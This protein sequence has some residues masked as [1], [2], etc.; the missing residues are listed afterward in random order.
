MQERMFYA[1]FVG[2]NAYPQGAALSGCV[3]DVLE[4][5]LL[6]REQCAQ[7]TGIRYNPVYY[8]APNDADALRME[9]HE[10]ATGEKLPFQPPTFTNIS[11]SLFSHFN[12]AKEGD[13]CVFYYSGHGSQTEAPPE[14]GKPMMETIVCVDSRDE[15]S[16]TAR[17]L[18]DKELAWLLWKTFSAKA[19]HVLVLMDCCHSGN[20]T[21]SLKNETD[22]RFRFIPSERNKIPYEQYLG[23]GDAGFYNNTGGKISIKI[24]RYVHL[25]ACRDDE[26]AQE[27]MQGG[28]FTNRL[29]EALRAGGTARS[30]RQLMQGLTISV[31][32]RAERQTPVAFALNE[33]DLDQQFLSPDIQPYKPYFNLRYN[34]REKRWKL[35]GGAMHRLKK[36]DVVKVSDGTKEVE[37]VLTDVQETYSWLDVQ[38]FDE[39]S[40]QITAVLLRAAEPMMKVGVPAALKNITGQFPFFSLHEETAP[41]VQYVVKQLDTGA[42]VLLPVNGTM[43][44]F[45]R[46]TNAAVFL[47]HINKVG[48]WLQTLELQH[49]AP[50][51][52][53]QDFVFEWVAEPGL[54]L[55]EGV[56]LHYDGDLYPSF[57]LRIS[58]HPQSPL[59]TCYVKAL[60]LGSKY[61]IIGSLIRND[62]NK[63]ENKAGSYIDLSM[64]YGGE[65]YTRIPVSI[66]EK[67]SRYNIHSVTDYLKII[68]S[69]KPVQLDQYEQEGLELD[70]GTVHRDLAAPPKTRGGEAAKDQPQ[71]SVFTFRVVCKRP[72][73]E[74]TLKAGEA[75]EFDTFSITAPA[76]FNARIAPAVAEN[77]T[78][79]ITPD[80]WGPVLTEE[81]LDGKGLLLYPEQPLPE[82]SAITLQLKPPAAA[83]RSLKDEQ[84]EEMILPYSFDPVTQQ[85]IPLGYA[86]DNGQV[87]IE[88]LPASAERSIG[89]AVKLYFKKIF[90]PKQ[91][92]QL[93]VPPG[94]TGKA[95][96]LIHGFTGETRSMQEAYAADGAVLTYDYE[97]MATPVAKTAELLQAALLQAG[98][99][100]TL[101]LTIVA[102]GT[103]GLV[104][105]WLVEQ[106]GAPYVKRLVLVGVPNAGSSLAA[107]TASATNLLTDALNFTG[108]V[109]YAITGLAWVLKFLKLHPATA[110]QEMQPGSEL[111]QKLQSSAMAKGVEY[112]VI[113][114]DASLIKGN[115]IDKAIV[116]AFG[117]ERNDRAVTVTSMQAIAG[118]EPQ[119]VDVVPCH[120]LGYFRKEAGIRLT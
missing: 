71:W 70:D 36:G 74:Q 68:V 1:A 116:H 46:E 52:R 102:H 110:F 109:K 79:S 27:T 101:E 14:F 15:N 77:T 104:A 80:L 98:A 108:P 4:L 113:A 5:D 20:N 10:T 19:A 50:G 48:S 25:A 117:K 55:A 22:V 86:D 99:D 95:T 84:L 66:D 78:R 9:A 100:K 62:S 88:R 37:A 59:K 23:Y 89:G 107:L 65:E 38:G 69:D 61:S 12:D 57:G 21:R 119:Q 41:G 45:K 92:N 112:K 90:R 72:P 91:V 81:V 120:H 28:L 63:L 6:F 83:V 35:Y 96:L 51:I 73:A 43:P 17:D 24:P 42:Y 115:L 103:G 93:V 18:I 47:A 87:F 11:A 118:L 58:I 44:L 64:A 94:L 40:Q 85:F 31:G 111:M 32:N 54:T 29:L 56:E 34:A 75:A 76:G 105:R 2:I 26:K 16:T 39:D 97:N 67:Y 53:Q 13:I 33:K 114:G 60:Y 49:Q 3:R 106:I 8:L 30:Y 7:Q 82:G